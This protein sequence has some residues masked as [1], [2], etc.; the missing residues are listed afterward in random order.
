MSF[1][2]PHNPYGQFSDSTDQQIVSTTEAQ[3]ITLNTDEYKQGITHSTV[4]NTSRMTAQVAGEYIV[5]ASMQ[6]DLISGGNKVFDFW[7]RV[8]GTDVPRSNY[9][10]FVDTAVEE[11]L[12]TL[13]SF[14]TLAVGN[15]VE[16]VMAGNSTELK[17]D[18]TV[19]AAS[20]TRPA[21]PSVIV[22]IFRISS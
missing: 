2:T 20:P 21:T 12:V 3:V 22:T 10:H 4:T 5:I 16:L 6:C 18:A 8:N 13:N 9:R 14:V 1:L 7:L 15:Y 11:S 19:A 17:L